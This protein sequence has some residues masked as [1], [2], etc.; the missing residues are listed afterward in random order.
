MSQPVEEIALQPS[1]LPEKT[2][3]SYL[4]QVLRRFLHHKLAVAGLILLGM[5]VFACLLAPLLA[6]YNPVQPDYTQIFAPPSARH[7]MGTDDLGHDV[8]SQWLWGGRIS[9][10][11]GFASMVVLSVVGTTVGMVSGYYGGWID[12]LL[13]RIV[14]IMLTIPGLLLV[15]LM[16]VVFGQSEAMIIIIIAGTGWLTVSRIVRAEFLSI[17][18]SNFVEAAKAAGCSDFRIMVRH[19]L[20]GALPAVL[21]NATLSMGIAIIVESSLSFLGFGVQPPQYSWGSML[22]LDQAYFMTAWWLAIFPG[23][24]IVLSVLAINFIGDGLRDAMDPRSF[25]QRR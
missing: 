2:E 11:I 22:G 18:A 3:P 21:V 8:F 1:R 4:Q 23:L 20:P 5:L 14:D 6:P 13:M 16:A 24:G 10:F 9:L 7:L 17:K 25:R 15:I 19:I 12:N